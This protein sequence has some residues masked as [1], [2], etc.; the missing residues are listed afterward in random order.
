[1]SKIIGIDLGTSASV[2]S[3]V[4]EGKAKVIVNQEGSLGTPSV[5]AITKSGEEIV[6]QTALRQITTNPE[7]TLFE[8]KRLIGRKYDDSE[9]Q[10]FKKIAPFKIIKN[11]NGDAWVEVNGKQYSPEEI[12]A[13]ILIKLKQAAEDYLGSTVEKAIVTVPAY[14]GDSQRAATKDAGKIAGLDVVRVISEPTAA[15]LA[16]GLDN[17]KDKNVLVADVGGGTTDYSVIS[18]TD[19]GVFETISTA[20]DSYLGGADFDNAITNYLADEFKKE[21]GIDLRNDSTANSRL[22]EAAEKAKKELSS[23]TQTDINLPFITADATGPKHLNTNLTRA[24][25]ESLVAEP[26]NRLETPLRQAI[27]DSGLSM[28]EIQEVLLVGGSTRV[29]AVQSKIELV[30]GKEALKGVNPDQV[31]SEGAAIQGAVLNNDGSVGDILLLDVTPLSLGLE[32]LGGVSTKIIDKNT[33]IPVTKSQVFSTAQDNQPAVSINVLQGEREFAADNKSLGRFDLVDIPPAPRGIP[34]IEV[35]FSIDA[36]GVVDVKA[37]DKATG[38]SQN[39]VIEG[40]SGLSEEEIQVAINDAEVNAES[41][42]A[43][44]NVIDKKN[45]LENSI[46]ALE[47]V[48]KENKENLPEDIIAKI[49]TALPGAKQK[50]VS[51][52]IEDIDVGIEELGKLTQEVYG[53]VA[54]QQ[55]QPGAGM[56]AANN[57]AQEET[58]EDADFKEI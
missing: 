9:V 15:A 48:V 35:T 4:E 31:V 1:M 53:E 12:S 43:R 58:V 3:V 26:L 11:K 10:E 8:I 39:I 14:F 24:K 54:K 25:F 42:E 40:G 38:K 6:G 16:Y 23:T 36:N 27:K 19:D 28:D 5:I 21:N 50:L 7:G 18:I 52:N 32:T 56:D 29:P 55:K 45:L 41:D 49:E 17:K 47:S 30:T 20:G 13:K 57:T 34:Q 2:V 44:K 46:N 33:T 37:S 22:K 51:D